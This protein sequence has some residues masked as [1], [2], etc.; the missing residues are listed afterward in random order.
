[1]SEESRPNMFWHPPSV[2]WGVIFG[3]VIGFLATGSCSLKRI[4]DAQERAHPA[5]A[6]PK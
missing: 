6:V 2:G 3:L 5:P 4:A 1:M